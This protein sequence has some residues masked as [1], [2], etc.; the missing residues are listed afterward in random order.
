VLSYS[1]DNGPALAAQLNAPQGVA[2]D[3]SGNIYIAD[4]ANHAVRK[5]AKGGVITNVIGNGQPGSGN[6]QLSSPAGVAADAS[7]NVYIA[8]TFNG[9]VL[10]VGVGG[11]TPL[12]SNDQLYTPV[13]IA[14]DSAGN[15]YVADLSRNMVRKLAASGGITTLAGNGNAGYSGDNGP[16]A[17]ALLNSPRGVAVDGSGNV[18]IADTGNFRIRKVTADGNISTIA[19]NGVFG[20]SGDAGQAV[21][22]QIGNVSSLA[23]DAAGN[24]YFTDGTRLRKIV[25]AGL[26]TTIA[27]NTP[28]GYSGDG[29]PSAAAQI[30]APA[31]IA[32]D[33]TG[34]LYL[35][36]SGNNAIRQ[37]QPLA[38]NFGISAVASAASLQSGVIAPG[39][40][41]VLFGS[42]MGPAGLVQAQ[43]NSAGVVGT[44]LVG[45]SVYLN[46]AAAPVLYTSANQVAVVAPF[47]LAGPK[48]DVIVTYQGQISAVLTVSVAATAP[49][50]FTLN[51]SG[52]G[53]AVAV[54]AD[55]SVN[56]AAHPAKAGTTVSIYATGG[57][58]TNPPSQDG[59]PGAVP[60]PRPV[61]PVSLTI[62]G[63]AATVQYAGAAVGL[64]SGALQ[65]NAQ[66]PDG[67]SGAV[68]VVL[69][70]GGSSS[71]NGITIYTSN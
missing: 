36:D 9:R 42:G 62:G 55:G 35:A 30:N 17:N 46:G 27:G 40:L 8:D 1:G 7:G 29:G 65:I 61:A 56:D 51:G 16:A 41:I 10:K 28:A 4:T 6:N 67:L 24:I 70:I 32:V 54:N 33:N 3:A 22:A 45:T 66:I 5:F 57:G 15:V 39:E 13:G 38:G 64:I 18:Y 47:N 21:N 43:L 63:K 50:L 14:V 34:A 58:Q 20:Y 69:Q 59:A 11:V 2:A 25:S 26:I 49:A 12:A 60:L 53:A 44:S 68:P 23:V 52:T 31:G 71:P 48:A 19:G 37:L